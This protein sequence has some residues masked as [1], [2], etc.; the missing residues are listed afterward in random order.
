MIF[1]KTIVLTVDGYSVNLSDSLKF[2]QND[3]I[4]LVFVIKRLRNTNIYPHKGYLLLENP[5]GVDKIES[6]ETEGNTVTFYLDSKNTNFIGVSRMQIIL[7]DKYGGQI[8]LPYMNFEVQ[9]NIYGDIQTVESVV[10]SEK[11]ETL[12]TN[13]DEYIISGINLE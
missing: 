1:S 6:M 7:V 12:L 9:K 10:T 3:K 2:Y 4:K 11:S 13:S 5:N 8:T